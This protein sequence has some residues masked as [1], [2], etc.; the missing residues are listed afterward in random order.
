MSVLVTG[1]AG[2]IGSHMVLALRDQGDEV[3]VLDNLSTGF[4]WAL[5]EDVPLVVGDVA[6]D[7]LLD[8]TIKDYGVTAIAHFAARIVVPESVADPLGYYLGNTAKTRSLLA[9][10]VRNGVESFIFS[11]TAAVYGNP[12][13]M[14]VPEDVPLEPVSPYG[15]S[16]LM[17]EW[18]LQ[19]TAFA[20]GL[21]YVVLRYFNVAGADPGGRTGQSTPAATHLIKVACQAALGLRPQLEVFGTDYDTPDGSCLRDYIQVSDLA[22]AHVAALDHLRAGGD[23]LTLNCGYGRGYSVLEVVEAVKRVSG[24]DIPVVLSPRRAGDPAA[25]VAE[26]AKI[27]S[28]LDWNPQFQ[29]LDMIVSQALAWE[30]GLADRAEN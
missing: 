27:K 21:K 7:A 16:K 24:V 6:D 11:S 8:K 12:P 29:N 19:D 25:I 20:H 3:V 13:V 15:R 4:R 9:S 10:A 2:Y 22:Q 1:G 5:P 18:M 26:V 30:K 28:T 14:P 23:N 17:S